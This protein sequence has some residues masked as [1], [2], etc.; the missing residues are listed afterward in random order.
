MNL[1]VSISILTESD[2]EFHNMVI[3]ALFN[4]MQFVWDLAY[5]TIINH[6]SANK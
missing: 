1:L 6:E 4:C 2:T 3:C 5:F